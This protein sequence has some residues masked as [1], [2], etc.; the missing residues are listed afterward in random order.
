MSR[1]RRHAGWLIVALGVIALGVLG[2]YLV[3]NSL[4][5]DPNGEAWPY[6]AWLVSPL[7]AAGAG[8]AIGILLMLVARF[9]LIDLAL[10]RA[11]KATGIGCISAP[12]VYI[13]S[14]FALGQ[15]WEWLDLAVSPD[16]GALWPLLIF[17]LP[18]VTGIATVLGYVVS[19]TKG[20]T[21]KTQEA[22][23]PSD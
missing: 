21:R 23:P 19:S 18:I 8:V 7:L 2:A 13:V 6:L 1:G 14:L 11:A 22:A 9:R 17:A 15:L 16:P 12:F 5:V 10:P 4:G 20:P 3:I